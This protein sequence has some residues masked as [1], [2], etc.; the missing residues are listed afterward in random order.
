MCWALCW[1]PG[2]Q[3]SPA[4][5]PA[6]RWFYGMWRAGVSRDVST[7]FSCGNGTNLNPL[8]F[9]NEMCLRSKKIKY[10]SDLRIFNENNTNN[11][12]PM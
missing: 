4:H 6:L 1:A 11:Y 2:I 7:G 9:F 3:S 10:F 5:I 12:I 8:F